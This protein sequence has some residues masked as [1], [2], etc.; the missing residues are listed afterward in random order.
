LHSDNNPWVKIHAP[1]VQIN[2]KAT[3]SDSQILSWSLHN[4]VGLELHLPSKQVS[5]GKD[6]L[7]ERIV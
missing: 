6:K 7:A 5:T 2:K 1:A 4:S 3:S